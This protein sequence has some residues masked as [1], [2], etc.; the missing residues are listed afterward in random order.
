MAI[1]ATNARV[2]VENTVGTATA[3]T[4]ITNANPGV[5]TSAGHGLTDGDV[6]KLAISDGMVELNEQVVRIANSATDTF[7]LEGIDTTDF[8][9]FAAGTITWQEVS[10]W[11]TI[12]AATSVNLGDA[13]P[14]ELDGTRLID[15]KTVT[16][17]GLPGSISGTIDIQHD[18]HSQAIQKLKAAAVSDLLA[19]R[20]TWNNG[21]IAIFGAKSAYSGGFSAAVNNILTGSIP[22]TVPAELVEY[23][24]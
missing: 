12:A 19:F 5:V 20:V 4:G 16:L 6:V 1:I 2:E 9:T 11:Y 22:V 18:P 8:G 17:Y 23:E 21:N 7:E 14:S 3:I 13:A 15:K 10:A 24:S